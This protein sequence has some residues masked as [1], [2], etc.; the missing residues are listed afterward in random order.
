MFFGRKCKRKGVFLSR[1]CITRPKFLKIFRD[2]S[3]ILFIIGYILARFARKTACFSPN[4]CKRKGVFFNKNC[5]EG[6][7]FGDCIGTPVYKN[8]ASA[9]PG[10]PMI[11]QN[12]SHQTKE[13]SILKGANNFFSHTSEQ[14]LFW[15]V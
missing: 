5:R 13:V 6:Y 3:A 9:P 14:I 4:N 8:Y 15:P 7:G 2:F 10:G 1:G 12:A 11:Y